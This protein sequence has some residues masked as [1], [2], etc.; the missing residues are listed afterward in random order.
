VKAWVLRWKYWLAPEPVLPGVWRM[1]GG[2]FY[3]RGRVRDPLSGKMREVSVPLPDATV[4]EAAVVLQRELHR[5]R[6]ELSLRVTFAD[7]ARRILERKVLRAELRSAKAKAQWRSILEHHLLPTFGQVAVQD[8]RRTTIEAWKDEVA[9][10]IQ[11]GDHSPVTANDWI[12][13]LRVIVNAAVVELELPKNPIAGVKGFD[14]SEHPPYTDE[15]PNALTPDEVPL[16]LTEMRRRFPQHFAM[17]ALGFATGLRPSSMRPLRRRG[18]KADVL[19]KE[20]VL[21][22]RRSHSLGDEVMERTKT[23]RNQR[24]ALPRE[25]VEIL[26]WHVANLPGP[27]R[28]SELL[29]P[30]ETG[31]FRSRSALDK[32]FRR[33]ALAVGLDKRVTP[34]A[35]RRTFQDLARAAEVEDIVT[36]AISGHATETMQRHYS[37][38][39]TEEIR[40]GVAR[41]LSLAGFQ[42]A[43]K[44]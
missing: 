19:W 28:E 10:G 7:Y 2:G 3:V 21:L 18:E 40:A 33:V 15:E 1:R 14:T 42:E 39:S 13:I 23:G 22:V 8:L 20:G 30:S 16:F 4:G 25:L 9:R 29:F 35:M 27:M 36:R 41:V 32:P 5:L 34:R 31:R 24:I 11:A 12:K 38:V 37:T 6:E 17:T 43:A 26:R 44:R